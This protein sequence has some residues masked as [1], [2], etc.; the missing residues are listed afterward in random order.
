MFSNF[1]LH[2]IVT[3]SKKITKCDLLGKKEKLKESPII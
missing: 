1:Q 3:I 2:L